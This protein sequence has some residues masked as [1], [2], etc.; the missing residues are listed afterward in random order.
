MRIVSL[1]SGCGGMDLGAIQAGGKVIWANELSPF[2]A[3]TYRHNIG[4]HIHE[5]DIWDHIHHIPPA[6]LVIG[7]FPC[8][9]F[10]MVWK[11]PGLNGER[12]NLYLAMVKAIAA[13]APKAFI[14][15]NVKGLLSANKGKAIQKIIQDFSDLGYEVTP[16][17]CNFADYGVPQTRERVLI[18]GT[19]NG[20]PAYTPPQPTHMDRP[21][22]FGRSVW[23]GA[24]KALE[25]IPA[26]TPNHEIPTHSEKVVE[27]L[28]MIPPGGNFTS[29]PKDH[30]LYIKGMISHVYRRLHPQRPSYTITGAGGGGTHGYHHEEP[31]S[32][33][34]RERARLSSFPDHFHFRGPWAEV[35][36]QIGN[37]VPPRGIA[38]WVEQ[39]KSV[40]T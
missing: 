29:I 20:L 24:A 38:P 32:L 16:Y 34:N 28:K 26:D 2:A 12:G 15:E 21:N 18:V 25:S 11:R 33:T 40:C 22:L 6:D 8:Q 4:S 31:R 3:A 5:G 23:I 19:R 27:R 14:A 36:R 39:M 10:S 37:A 30:P 7:G 1:F 13:A 17:L 9:D 35:R